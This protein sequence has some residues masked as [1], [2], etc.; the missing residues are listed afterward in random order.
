MIWNIAQGDDRIFIYKVFFIL[1]SAMI[2]FA[3]IW[4]KVVKKAPAFQCATLDEINNVKL[5]GQCEYQELVTNI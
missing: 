3:V 5:E 2:T 1:L 4:V